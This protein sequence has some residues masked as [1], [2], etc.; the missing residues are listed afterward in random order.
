MG[1]SEAAQTA[2]KGMKAPRFDWLHINCASYLGPNKWYDEG[3]E[4]FHPENIIW[5]SRSANLLG[6][7]DRKTGKDCLAGGP[8]L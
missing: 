7:T 2:M 1:F 4:R 6:I 5:D 8:G 3:D